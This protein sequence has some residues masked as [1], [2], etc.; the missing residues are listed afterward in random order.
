M[1]LAVTQDN[2]AQA[3][4]RGGQNVR[5]ASELT[6]WKLNVMSE[7]QA[8]ERQE[9]ESEKLV[10]MFIARLDVDEELAR[11]LVDEGFTSVDEVA[12][13]PVEE[14]LGID[15]F[16]EELVETLRTRARDVLLTAALSGE[17]STGEPADDLLAMEFMTPALAYQLA[18]RGV[19]TMEDLAE[20]SVDELTQFDGVDESLAA[21]LIMKAREPWFADEDAQENEQE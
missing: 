15:G 14:M 4:G 8:E 18:D 17:D 7:E 9:A 13:V 20:L 11:I 2:L 19:C 10:N 3:I 1:D 21:A 16:E 6:G 12:Y 5:L